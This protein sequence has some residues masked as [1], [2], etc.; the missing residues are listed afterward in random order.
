MIHHFTHRFGDYADYPPGAQTTALPDVP[1][2][3]LQDPD[4]RVR[5]RY[6]VP[7]EEVDARLAGKWDRGWLLG[8]RDVC[9]STDERTVIA[10]VIPRVGVGHKLPLALLSGSAKSA[11]CLTANLASFAFDYAARQKV[12][13]TSLTYFIMKQLPVLP[14]SV[15]AAKV[16]W[17]SDENGPSLADWLTE[18]V[19][20]LAYTASDLAPFARDCGYDGPPFRWDEDRRSR[21]RREIDAVFFHLYGL[22]RDDVGYIMETFPIV[23]RDDIKRHGDYRTKG[24]ILEMYDAMAAA[25]ETSRSHQS[26]PDLSVTHRL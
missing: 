22:T 23:R 16:P 18:R 24:V 19:V 4:Y 2:E 25:T 6:W 8:W 13:G 10:S 5:P 14:P 17:R 3:R 26:A 9:R 11:A 7:A 1:I 21:L 20:E 15:Y 12:G